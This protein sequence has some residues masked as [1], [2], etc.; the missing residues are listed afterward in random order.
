MS[1][2]RLPQPAGSTSIGEHDGDEDMNVGSSEQEDESCEKEAIAP[3]KATRDKKRVASVG[4]FARLCAGGSFTVTAPSE[5]LAAASKL[6][7]KKIRR[8]LQH[9][10][11]C[12]VTI[13]ARIT[14]GQNVLC[15][16]HTFSE[17]DSMWSYERSHCADTD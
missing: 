5:K 17:T 6:L 16:N 12:R 2:P 13:D 9:S 8:L 15:C 14:P 10:I 11:S 3:L 7:S 4:T 1:S